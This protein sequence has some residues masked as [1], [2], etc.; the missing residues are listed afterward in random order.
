M[1]NKKKNCRT[2]LS[3]C[4]EPY[5]IYVNFHV[6]SSSFK[7]HTSCTCFKSK[8]KLFFFQ[9]YSAGENCL[10]LTTIENCGEKETA[11]P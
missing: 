3:H 6:T 10:L 2:E 11:L 9:F 8:I 7:Y 1:R 5:L 4:N